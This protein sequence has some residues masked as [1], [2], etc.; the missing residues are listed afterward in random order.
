[1]S[2]PE[3]NKEVCTGCNDCV[4]AC[5]TEAITLISEKAQIDPEL[6]SECSI[7][8]DSCPVDAITED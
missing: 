5:P 2:V 4:D 6:C 1:M 3:I 7:C 8:V